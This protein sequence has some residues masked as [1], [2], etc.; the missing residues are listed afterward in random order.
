MTMPLPFASALAALRRRAPIVYPTETFYG[1]GAPALD[2]D[3][4]AAVA[5]LKGRDAAKPIAVLVR[6]VAML[7]RVV[8]RVPAPARLLIDRFW[9]GPLTLVLPARSD[10]APALTGG[11]GTI[12]VR[13]SSSPTAHALVDALGEPLTTTSANPGGEPPACDVAT[14]RRYFG[15]AVAEYVDGG[16]L[17]GGSGSTVLL[18]A[19]DGAR[20]I[21]RGA[22][23]VDALADVLGSIPLDVQA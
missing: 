17:A 14:A 19:D 1:L 4:V 7:P 3:A 10:L 21:R 12:G 16:T 18:V 11:T 5:A 6:D 2:R 20:V 15:A 13:V 9:P 22:V 23:P 8:A